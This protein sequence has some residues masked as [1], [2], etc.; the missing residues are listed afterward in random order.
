MKK[1]PPDEEWGFNDHLGMETK[2]LGDCVL[3]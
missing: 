2:L 3:N 1:A